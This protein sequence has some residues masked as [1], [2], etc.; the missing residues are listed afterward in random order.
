[1]DNIQMTRSLIGVGNPHSMVPMYSATG[2][3]MICPRTV[4]AYHYPSS[5]T[6]PTCSSDWGNS[7]SENNSPVEAYALDQSSVYLPAPTLTPTA[8]NVYEGPSRWSLP[9][10]RAVEYESSTYVDQEPS[11][12][13]QSLPH[14]QTDNR[15]SATTEVLSPLNMSSLQMNLPERSYIPRH[16]TKET[17]TPQRQLPMPQ[18]S[19][20]LTARNVVDKMQDQRLRS[21]QTRTGNRIAN[22]T[23]VKPSLPWNADGDTRPIVSPEPVSMPTT[24]YSTT[25]APSSGNIECTLGYA[26]TSNAVNNYT[27]VTDTAPQ[28]QL[29]FSTPMP[30]D[31]ISIPPSTMAYSNFRD[32]RGS[33]SSPTQDHRPSS[34]SNACAIKSDLSPKR[35]SLSG[36]SQTPYTL[37]NGHQCTSPKHLHS[38]SRP[39][40]KIPCRG[41]HEGKHIPFQR[42]PT[43]NVRSNL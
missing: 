25:S 39:T 37:V 18:P 40:F 29:D 1:M 22:N 27:P 12:T 15:V 38:T 14:I 7:Y 26:P 31:V 41:I 19:P 10:T 4:P 16:Q 36:V 20:A 35:N 43:S 23:F 3:S 17:A 13:T 30:Y 34:Q 28:L 8:T 33:V 24:T 6:K 2:G 21:A 5:D 9:T 32:Y 11:Y 42:S